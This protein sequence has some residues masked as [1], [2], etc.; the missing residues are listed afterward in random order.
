VVCRYLDDWTAIKLRWHL[1]ADPA[2]PNRLT[3]PAADCPNPPLYTTK[4]D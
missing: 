4:A 1:A 2:D 3:G